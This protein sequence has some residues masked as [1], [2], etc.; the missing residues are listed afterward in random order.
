[1][2]VKMRAFAKSTGREF[3]VKWNDYTKEVEVVH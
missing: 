1:M 3:G 2:A